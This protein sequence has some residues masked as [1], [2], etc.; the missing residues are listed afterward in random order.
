MK[1]SPEIFLTIS[2]IIGAALILAMLAV[3]DRIIRHV[4][5]RESRRYSVLWLFSP[6]WLLRVF[7]MSWFAEARRAGFLPARASLFAAWLCYIAACA[8]FA[9]SGKLI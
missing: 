5:R 1:I 2:A 6:Y 9:P 7:K 4:C 3:D 8:Y